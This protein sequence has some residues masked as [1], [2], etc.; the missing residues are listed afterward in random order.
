VFAGEWSGVRQQEGR[1]GR[2]W[3]AVGDVGVGLK[4]FACDYDTPFCTVISSEPNI[5]EHCDGR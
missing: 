1:E 4:A 5:T 3:K 2:E